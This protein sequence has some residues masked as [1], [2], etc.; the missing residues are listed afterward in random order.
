MQS[1]PACGTDAA[2][3]GRRGRR[4]S[5]EA[6][7]QQLLDCAI[8][9][10]AQISVDRIGHGDIAK[11]A[12]VSTATVFNYFPT[13]TA[14]I[15]AVLG[16]ITALVEGLFDQFTSMPNFD[17]LPPAQQFLGLAATYNNM[18]A[19]QPQ[20]IKAF[21][22]WSVTFNPD[23]RPQYLAFQDRVLSRLTEALPAIVRS[24]QDA[25]IIYGAANMFATMRIDG[26]SED[27]LTGFIARLSD[28]FLP[29]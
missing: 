6:R 2:R 27:V 11:L 28:A 21:L 23:V 24:E 22:N 5:P 14:L 3:A 18:I 26:A 16:E 10:C 9:A 12:H 1:T 7:Q 8:Q 25:R 29:H 4:L 17:A 19:T 13:R 20:A 15:E